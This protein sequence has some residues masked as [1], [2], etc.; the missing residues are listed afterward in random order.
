MYFHN[1]TRTGKDMK[2]KRQR[3]GREEE[4]VTGRD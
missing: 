4:G 1:I 2:R 3:K